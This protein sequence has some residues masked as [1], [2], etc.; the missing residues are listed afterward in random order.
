MY[1]CLYLLSIHNDYCSSMYIINIVVNM[2]DDVCGIET[3]GDW[4]ELS[5]E[6]RDIRS[7]N[8]SFFDNLGPPDI[9]ETLPKT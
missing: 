4:V 7:V 3:Q 8:M 9:G 5:L 1:A 2:N 6:M